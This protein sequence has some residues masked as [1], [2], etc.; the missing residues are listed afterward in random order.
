MPAPF[1]GDLQPKASAVR[2]Y[3]IRKATAD[4]PRPVPADST[5]EDEQEEEEDTALPA[6]TPDGGVAVGSVDSSDE[7]SPLVA[8]E[9]WHAHGG[10]GVG[11]EAVAPVGDVVGPVL[12]EKEI[13]PVHEEAKRVIAGLGSFAYML[14]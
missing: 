14:R 8:E 7:E 6:R 11:V 12:V 4:A 2:S 13:R 3:L 10:L 9:A 5:D 1:F